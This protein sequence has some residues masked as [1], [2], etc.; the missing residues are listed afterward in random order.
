MCPFR[1]SRPFSCNR[2]HD[3][4]QRLARWILESCDRIQ[5]DDLGLTHEF[6]GQKLGVRRAGVSEGLAALQAQ[7]LIDS[8]RKSIKIAD[9]DGLKGVA[10]ECYEVIRNEY[11]RLLGIHAS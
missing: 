2:Q 4:N 7:G 10:C 6:I 9:V 5:F 1:R 3:V 11:D 8:G